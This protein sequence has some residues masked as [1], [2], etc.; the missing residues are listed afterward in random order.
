MAGTISLYDTA[1]PAVAVLLLLPP[2]PLASP[3]PIAPAEPAAAAAADAAAAAAADALNARGDTE[4][5]ACPL[6][7]EH[8][9][10]VAA[11]TG[12]MQSDRFRAAVRHR[13]VS[14]STLNRTPTADTAAPVPSGARGERWLS[15]SWS[16]RPPTAMHTP[17]C[18]PPP[19]P[20]PLPPPLPPP[21]PPPPPALA[22]LP[23]PA[24]PPAPLLPLLL[25]CLL[26]M[27]CGGDVSTARYN[28]PVTKWPFLLR[29]PKSRYTGT[30]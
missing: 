18:I 1:E 25:P 20:L 19:P 21:P 4:P 11:A 7:G 9:N 29:C 2:T 13:L 3:P 5:G 15:T 12:R 28:K 6:A 14:L 16:Y 27:G 17:S 26:V 23:P 10:T 22:A 24:P 8:T 30:A